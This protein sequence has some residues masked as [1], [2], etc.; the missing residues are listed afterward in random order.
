LTS[1]PSNNPLI[2]MSA[3]LRN[4]LHIVIIFF[5]FS[6]F[7]TRLSFAEK[8]QEENC[9]NPDLRLVSAEELSSKLSNP[10]WLSI[11]G[12][13]FDVTTGRSFYG[14]GEGYSFFAGKDAS[15][16]YITGQFNDEGLKKDIKTLNPEELAGI[17]EWM[18][19][20]E[21]HETYNFVGLLQGDFYD[22]EGNP[23]PLLDDI[24]KKIA[25]VE[26]KKKK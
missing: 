1:S 16:T 10:I 26:K 24:N 18:K 9:V 15:Q 4:L 17:D 11:L 3:S 7:S 21:D 25:T 23:T 6:A 19:F 12:Q 13:V 8:C 22:S 2:A 5:L 14:P 20:Y